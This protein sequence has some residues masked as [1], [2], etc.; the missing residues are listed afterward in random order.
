MRIAFVVLV[1]W[2]S[3]ALADPATPTGLDRLAA[4]L[5]GTW[6]TEGQTLDSP[7]TK[8]GPQKYITQRDCWREADSYKCVFVVNG[9]LQL[10]DIF[11]WDAQDKLYQETQ[12]TPKGRQPEFHI[13]VTSD[14]WTYDQ[15][16]ARSDGSV[17]HYRIVR[18]YASTSSASYSY[19]FSTDGKQW[20]EIAKGTETRMV[21]DR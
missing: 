19:S 16:I 11:S 18:V 20:T 15:D 3:V 13:S 14:T 5:P 9:S 4:V 12:I 7:F 8:A 1:L 2:V 21:S 10:Y 17:I 6:N